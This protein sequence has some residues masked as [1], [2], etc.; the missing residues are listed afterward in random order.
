M[1][2]PTPDSIAIDTAI[3]DNAGI[4]RTAK[5]DLSLPA[6]V[7]AALKDYYAGEPT[8][9]RLRI[10]LKLAVVAGEREGLGEQLN[11]SLEIL[12]NI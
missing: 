4:P 3:A 6:Q 11:S 9:E 10:L 5:I 1:T 7:E 2:Y 8:P 12:K